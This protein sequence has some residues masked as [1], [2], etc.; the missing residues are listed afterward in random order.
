[1]NM[2]WRDEIIDVTRQVKFLPESINGQARELKWLEQMGDW[3]IS[4]KRFWGLALPIWVC[5]KCG[6]FD[7]I[8]GR[9]ELRKRAIAGWDRFDGNSPHRP[10]VDQVKI[11]C[12]QCGGMSSRIPDVG[13]PWLDAGIVPYSTMGY[14]RDR[15][16][17]EKWFPADFITTT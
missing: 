14:N 1:M 13:N 2:S 4:K 11:K 8:G 3:M 6:A 12:G 5:E 15:S 9:D 16:Y 7:V 17:C 10:W